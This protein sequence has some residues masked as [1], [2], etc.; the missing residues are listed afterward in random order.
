[1]KPLLILTS[2]LTSS[3]GLY[4]QLPFTFDP[5]NVS[6][7][8]QIE[9]DSKA[10][11][12]IVTYQISIAKDYFPGATKYD[13]AQPLIFIRDEKG[14]PG[15]MRVE[16]FYTKSDEKVRLIVYTLDSKS[17]TANTSKRLSRRELNSKQIQIYNERYAQLL[18]TLTAELG[19]PS[20]GNGDVVSVNEPSYGDY[21]ERR[22]L[23]KSERCSAELHMLWT[24]D[25]LQTAEGYQLVHNFK[26][27]LMVYWD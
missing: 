13:L 8:R 6:K 23:W 26:I 9:K 18:K 14:A 10:E 5:L 25:D 12:K 22:A 24:E 17:N 2:I 16:Y 7:A 27:R 1:M 21:K 19:Q 3:L 20:E 4:A 15:I 11:E